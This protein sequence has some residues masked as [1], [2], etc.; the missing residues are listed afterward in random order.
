MKHILL[1]LVAVSTTL[2]IVTALPAQEKNWKDP[3]IVIDQIQ[4]NNVKITD[5]ASYLRDV[6]KDKID[7]IVPNFLGEVTLSLRLKA[8]TAADAFQAMNQLFQAGGQTV[9]WALIMNGNRP[10]ALFYDAK[11]M[12]D[13]S[14]K[15]PEIVARTILYIG[16]LI[17]EKKDGGLSMNDLVNVITGITTNAGTSPGF[18]LQRHDEAQLLV[19]RGTPEEIQFVREAVQAL[20]V[21]ATA[22][23]QR[24]PVEPV[25]P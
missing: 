19:V 24:K 25:K 12:L 8:V 5:V 2:F 10:T 20:I 14:A 3:G 16:D 7:V 1:K 15:K 17:G 21:R 22:L 9:Q 18:A 4:F 6:F 11:L 13:P 23:R